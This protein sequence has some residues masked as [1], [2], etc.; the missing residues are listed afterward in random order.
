[1]P[2]TGSGAV[3]G[4]EHGGEV[5]G[6]QRCDGVRGAGLDGVGEGKEPDQLPVASDESDGVPVLGGR[7]RALR[8]LGEVDAVL[9]EQVG[10]PDEEGAPGDVGGAPRP[11]RAVSSNG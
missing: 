5:L 6:V 9:A 2:S 7:P 8:L 4:E 1:M 3:A 10:V 11:G